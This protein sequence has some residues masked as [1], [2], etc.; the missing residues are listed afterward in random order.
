MP[1]EYSAA[2]HDVLYIAQMMCRE[3]GRRGGRGI[4]QECPTV[5]TEDVGKKR[6]RCGNICP[7]R[8][9]DTVP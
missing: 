6:E 7:V 3:N 9:V 2:N 5:T 8:G 4:V 1:E